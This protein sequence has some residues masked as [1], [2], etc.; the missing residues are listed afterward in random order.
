MVS[1]DDVET[2]YLLHRARFRRPEMR[3]LRHILVTINEELPGS[4][5]AAARAKI[6]AIG[7]R[8]AQDPEAFADQALKYSECPSALNGGQLG[9]FP[10]GVLYAEIE[11]AAFALAPD[12]LSGPIES[13]LGFHLVR[14]D[15]VQAEAQLALADVRERIR[16]YMT[17][18]RQAAARKPSAAASTA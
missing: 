4:G 17:R 7:A 14:C 18:V 1:D 3:T 8:L 10:R 5:R 6:D 11:A 12:E 9:T 2:F 13:P 16:A 15:A